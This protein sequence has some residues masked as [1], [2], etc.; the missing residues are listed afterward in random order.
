M[1]FYLADKETTIPGNKRRASCNGLTEYERKVKLW[2]SH[3]IVSLAD[4]KDLT[5]S[6][7]VQ[8]KFLTDANGLKQKLIS[9][10]NAFQH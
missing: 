5:H 6:T 10:A 3:D 8:M 9:H 2:Y 7:I 1:H 4:A